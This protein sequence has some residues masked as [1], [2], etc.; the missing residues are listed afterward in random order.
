MKKILLLFVLSAAALSSKAQ[1]VNFK[2]NVPLNSA[3]QSVTTM[4][5][6][7]DGAQ[8][9][10]MDMV[11]KNTLTNTKQEG[12]TFTFQSITNAVKVDMDAG[13]MTMS[14]DSENPSDDEMSK[15]LAGEMDKLIGKKITMN[16]SAKGELL[17]FQQENEEDGPSGNPFENMGIT[18]SY[19]DKAVNPGETWESQVENAGMLVKMLNKYVGKTAD[20]Y[21]IESK[22]EVLSETSEKLGDYLA[23]Y[24]LD[25]K[26]HFTKTATIKMDM[27]I[28]GQKV[29]SEVAVTNTP[30]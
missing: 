8:S 5:T 2:I 10:I 28:Q 7:L 16:M 23:N 3:Y 1:Q 4:K 26:T 17:N 20:G 9:M 24:T 14:Y 29:L 22:G 11:V 12:G 25:E 18:A 13:M 27:S 6:D 21:V 15:M 30:K 19:P